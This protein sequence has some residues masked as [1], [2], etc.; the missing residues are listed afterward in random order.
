MVG[1]STHFLR[2]YFNF[3][4]YLS[5]VPFR[6]HR[7]KANDKAIVKNSSKIKTVTLESRT[8]LG[9]A[10]IYAEILFRLFVFWSTR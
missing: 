5:L 9:P 3:G 6:F 2:V 4:Y 10:L 1:S 7:N 8:Y